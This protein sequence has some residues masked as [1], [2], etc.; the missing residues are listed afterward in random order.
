VGESHDVIVIGAGVAGALL[1]YRL[2]RKGHRVLLIESGPVIDRL[3]A[4]KAY[5]TADEKTP[6]SPYR[7][8]WNAAM[9]PD[10]AA[11][12]PGRTYYRQSNDPFK[13][14]YQRAVGGSTWHWLGNVPR[15]VPSD[16]KMAT[17]Y[18]VGVDWPLSYMDLE[19]WYAEAEIELGVAGRHEQ[20]DG[21]LGA[22]RSTPFPMSEIWPSYSDLLVEEALRGKSFDG[23]RLEVLR[24]PQARNSRPYDGRPACAGNSSCVPVCPIQAKY[25]AS[26]HV[27]KAMDH[28]ADLLANTTVVRLIPD[29]ESGVITGAEYVGKDKTRSFASARL[30][31]LSAHAIE[32]ARLLLHSGIANSSDQVGRNLMDHLNRFAWIRARTPMFPFRGPPTTSGIDAFRDGDFRRTRAAF[33]LSLGN[34]GAGRAVKLESTVMELAEKGLLGR[35]FRDAL[36]GKTE[37]LF[38]ISCSAEVLP[39]PSNR[40]AQASVKDENGIP[41]PLMH[42]RPD[43]YSRAGYLYAETVMKRIFDSIGYEDAAKFEADESTFSGAGHIMGTCRMGSDPRTSVVDANCRSHDHPNLFVVGSS[44]FPTSGTANPTLTVAALA[45]R[46]ASFLDRALAST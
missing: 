16:F 34:D 45:L 40:I 31:V 37:T 44:V 46:L 19:K 21:L 7:K 5:A 2:R 38:R 35:A 13:S 39:R 22:Y 28:G 9:R 42:F 20:W 3:E 43:D 15:L 8:L 41:F 11:T 32:S 18:G 29:S 33:R 25:D 26:L 24:T 23:V 27:Q 1:T 4:V 6:G 12:D 17:L 10:D 30:V 14:T 36:R